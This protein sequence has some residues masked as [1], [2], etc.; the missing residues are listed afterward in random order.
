MAEGIPFDPH[1][2]DGPPIPEKPSVTIYLERGPREDTIWLSQC[3]DPQFDMQLIAEG[4]ATAIV[5]AAKYRG[6]DPVTQLA[7]V[8]ENLQQGVKF[9]GTIKRNE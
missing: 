4:L 6:I 8:V 3:V 5:M 9:H 2:L 7:E 1:S